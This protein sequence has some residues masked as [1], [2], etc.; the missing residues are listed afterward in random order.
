MAT[1]AAAKEVLTA[2]KHRLNKFYNP[3]LDAAAPKQ[4]PADS[5]ASVLQA[6]E[7]SD[8]SDN[9]DAGEAM[10]IQIS[11]RAKATDSPSSP[12][13]TLKQR[14]GGSQ[15]SMGV[16]E[17]ID[18]LIKDLDNQMTEAEATEK[19]AQADYESLVADSADKRAHDSKALSEKESANADM[20]GELQVHSDEKAAGSKELTATRKYTM[21]LHH[22][23]DWL[24]KYFDVRK[25]ARTDEMVVLARSR[26]ALSGADYA[27]VQT[28]VRRSV[29]HM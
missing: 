20:E 19:N 7:S 14:K 4:E 15:E 9:A 11:A 1:S 8:Q 21:S 23:C 25:E 12:P 29:R 2:A 28:G 5:T 16:L 24:L 3:K 13:E 26:A 18:L 27:L 6:S 17:M 22:D 10:L